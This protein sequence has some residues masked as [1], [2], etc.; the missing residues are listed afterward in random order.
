[1]ERFVAGNYS[2]PNSYQLPRRL[3]GGFYEGPGRSL[4]RADPMVWAMTE[5]MLGKEAP[6]PRVRVL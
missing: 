6:E 3:L 1:M 4:D 2:L 5:L